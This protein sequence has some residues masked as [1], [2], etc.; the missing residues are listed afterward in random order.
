M[1]RDPHSEDRTYTPDSELR[2]PL[3]LLRSMGSDMVAG[4]ELAW[5]LFVRDTA[6]PVPAVGA[7]LFLGDP[8][9]AGDQRRLHPPELGQ[10]ARQQRSGDVL[11]RLRPHRHRLLRPLLRRHGGPAED[12]DCLQ[13]HCW[14]R[15]ASHERRFCSRLVRRRCSGFIIRIALLA[16]CLVFLQA[17]IA[18]TCTSGDHP[19]DRPHAV[20]HHGGR[21]DGAARR[22]VPGHH[23]SVWCC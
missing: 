16:V 1:P 23:V 20:R 10:C 14:S 4:R 6:C 3:R 12:R 5:R 15:C 21:S 11:P 22:P 7:R 9:T 17:H 19:R 13:G 2:H 8:S 18:P